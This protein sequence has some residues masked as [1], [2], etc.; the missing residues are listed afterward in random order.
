M[1]LTLWMLIILEVV[2]HV[3]SSS[4]HSFVVN[5]RFIVIYRAVLCLE[6]LASDYDIFNN[7]VCLTTLISALVTQ[8]NLKAN[9]SLYAES[10]GM[11]FKRATSNK[12]C[13]DGNVTFVLFHF[14]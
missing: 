7:S 14:F 6:Y 5:I 2:Y 10:Q 11:L 13:K 1:Q 8:K 4:R 3:A 12:S 9:H